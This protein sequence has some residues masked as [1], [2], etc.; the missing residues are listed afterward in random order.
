MALSRKIVFSKAQSYRVTGPIFGVGIVARS[1]EFDTGGGATG[2]VVGL[3]TVA[4][5]G[6][7]TLVDHNPSPCR[8]GP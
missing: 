1:G 6:N 7:A 4:A 8:D 2:R 3:G 5:S